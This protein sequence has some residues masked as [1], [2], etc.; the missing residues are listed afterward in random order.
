M[1]DCEAWR[2]GTERDDPFDGGPAGKCAGLKAVG[3][4]PKV[5]AVAKRDEYVAKSNI[6]G[7]NEIVGHE[8]EMSF[9]RIKLPRPIR[10]PRQS[11]CMHQGKRGAG[12][13]T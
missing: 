4:Q 10:I 12:G 13:Q 11:S 2:T 3:A 6:Y 7:K 5:G 8:A 1:N 9:S